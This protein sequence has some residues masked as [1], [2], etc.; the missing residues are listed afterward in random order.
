LLATRE[1]AL[2]DSVL[3][4]ALALGIDLE[5]IPD[6]E[7]L[8]HR[9]RT[10]SLRLVGTD[11]ASRAAT[12]GAVPGVWVVGF[13]SDDLLQASAE[14]GAPA[15]R[16]PGESQRLA[17]VL[18]SDLPGQEA[19]QLLAVSGVSGGLGV[20]S[21]VVALAM[22]AAESGLR[23][24]VVELARCGGGLDLLFGAETQPGMTWEELRHAVGEVGDLTPHLVLA[25]RVSVLALGRPHG[26]PPD[27]AALSAV[28]RSLERSHD[29]VV[30]DMGD[31]TRLAELGRRVVSLL[32][33][34][35]D[36]RSVAA[37]RMQARRLDLAGAL[38][39]VRAGRGRGLPPEAV[40]DALGLPLD[41]RHVAFSS[42]NIG[43]A[44]VAGH[45][46][47]WVFIQSVF[48]VLLIGVVNLVVS[49]MLT[50]WVALRSREAKI[51]SW[52]G[53]FQCAWQQI[54]AQPM[55]LFYPKDLPADA[56][57]QGQAEKHGH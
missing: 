3:A 30:V 34:G 24:A 42:A 26:Y 56:N 29:I 16:L 15:L 55:N 32:V 49:F 19:A 50:L 52:L 45:E 25:E 54:R 57:E 21:L 4:T 17:E 36:V 9:W 14:L 5:V 31:G 10:A 2:A 20:S 40:A 35:A 53:I 8:R 39:V 28:L 48:F 51:D 46:G 1:A 11:M 33:V 27:E 41:I 38:L 37:A 12:L 7:D 44:A 22:R 6:R 13:E 18:A 47:L 43:Y 23:P